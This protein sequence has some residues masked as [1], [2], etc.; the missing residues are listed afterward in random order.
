MN[1]V[2]VLG[3]SSFLGSDIVDKLL[4]KGCKVVGF[5][6]SYKSNKIMP[7]YKNNNLDNYIYLQYNISNTKGIIDR[8]DHFKPDTIINYT[9]LGMVAESW[10]YPGDYFDTNIVALSKLVK[11]LSTKSYLKRFIQTSTPEVYGNIGNDFKEC[12]VY[13]PNTPYG[14]SKAA[15][16]MYLNIMYK[17]AN[18]PVMYTRIANVCGPYQQLYRIIPKTII[19]IKKRDKLLLHGGGLSKR[20]FIHIDDASY[21]TLDVAEKGKPNNIYH[22]SS[23]D[24]LSIAELVKLICEKMDYN[25]NSLVEIS[26]DRTGKDSE[27][28]I[29][30][31]KAKQ[32]LGWNTTKTLS[33]AI[34]ETIEWIERNWKYIQHEE[35]EYKWR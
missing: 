17:H 31:D 7:Y 4:D 13:K 1:K 9:A 2:A 29:N 30:C 35:V 20:Y 3:C 34:D 21:G 24:Y 26:P 10:I 14:V 22:F 27:Y 5:S 23:N 18:F 33:N 25:Y 19:Q 15:F 11:E 6:R 28:K 8:L 32:E 16:D 12:R